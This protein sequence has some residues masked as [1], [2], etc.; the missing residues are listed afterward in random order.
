[1]KYKNSNRK[2]HK[3]S[4]QSPQRRSLNSACFANITLPSLALRTLRLRKPSPNPLLQLKYPN[5]LCKD[6]LCL[7]IF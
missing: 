1:M 5:K 3:V 2:E 6:C 7:H 4:A